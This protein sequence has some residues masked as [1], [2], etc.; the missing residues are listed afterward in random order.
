MDRKYG[1]L[2][3][4]L[5]PTLVVLGYYL[6]MNWITAFFVFV[7]IPILDQWLGLDTQNPSSEREKE[8]IR[9][10]FY[11]LIS[12]S[13]I[14]VQWGILGWGSWACLSLEGVDFFFFVLGVALT[15]GGIGITAAHELG[16]QRD[17]L[18]QT[19]AQLILCSVHYTHFFIEHNNGHHVHVGTP[20]DPATA[21]RGES[22][23][24]FWPRTV[25]GSY[26]NAWKFEIRR[27]K[28]L[29]L[30]WFSLQN[31]MLT[32]AVGQLGFVALIW[33]VYSLLWGEVL[34]QVVVFLLVQAVLAFTL[35][36]LVNYVEHYGLERKQLADGRYERTDHQ[37]SWNDSHL[38][39]N[40]FLFQLQRHSDHHAFTHRPY[41]V[42]RHYDESP[43]LPA[44]YPVMILM[45]LL[46]PLW[47]YFMDKKIRT[48]QKT[49]AS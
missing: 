9:D 25:W 26:V 10:G 1:Y 17:K 33:G 27:M 38:L 12:R 16:H 49:Y 2:W 22:F 31:R 30:P 37:H 6:K 43:Q 44:G 45:A 48:W 29:D 42:L 40:L 34:W 11:A 4:Y 5:I 23:Y 41:Q 14:F 47:F 35:L 46:P 15:T 7:V 19:L 13:W 3:A 39:S 32:F 18:S 20:L 36:E 28:K 8:Q 24:R 21:K